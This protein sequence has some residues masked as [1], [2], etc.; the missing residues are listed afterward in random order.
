VKRAFGGGLLAVALAVVFSPL[1]AALFATGLDLGTLRAAFVPE[2]I[3]ALWVTLGI[4][5]VAAL[6]ALGLGAPFA[7]LAARAR[8]VLGRMLGGL[9]ILVLVLPPYLSAAAWIDLLGPVGRLSLPVLGL[10]GLG[11]SAEAATRAQLALSGFVYTWPSVGIVLGACFFPIVALSV[12]SVDRRTDRRLFEAARIAQGR[13]GVLVVGLRLLGPAAIGAALLVFAATL[14]EF[15]VPQILRVRTLGE[16]VYDRIQE[17]ALGGAAALGLP[18]LPIVLLAGVVGAALVAR[19]R[20]ASMA[21]LE[22]DVPRLRGR[23]WGLGG[24]VAAVVVGL[25][26]LAPGLGFP[27]ASLTLGAATVPDSSAALPTE[28]RPPTKVTVARGRVRARGLVEALGRAWELASEDARRSVAY[29]AISASLATALALALGRLAR[30]R[31]VGVLQ[32]ALGAGLAVPAP[33]VGLGLVVI[34]N[35]V[36][37]VPVVGKLDLGPVYNG[38]TIVFLGWLARFLPIAVF[39]A[40]SALAQVPRELEDAAALAGRGPAE[41]FRTVV[42]PIAAPGLIAAWVS[43]YVLSATEFS[44]TVLVL[45]P[46]RPLLA[47]TVVNMIHYGQDSQI[48]ACALLLLGVVTLPLVAL[49]FVAA[50]ARR[51]LGWSVRSNGVSP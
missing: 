44:A 31:V 10:L 4:A 24:N 21:G 48:A 45:A 3:Q 9:A 30:G 46:G 51:A 17:G 33:I 32:G 39:L 34:W 43:V 35:R 50:V 7:L 29:A 13:R 37:H 15:A 36:V 25:I 22:G 41:R 28:E 26:A 38:A 40:R 23:P 19:A 14:T 8:P 18:L 5:G 12:A 42:L 2:S 20:L 16:D 47:P 6:T 1:L 11:P 27:L 49:A